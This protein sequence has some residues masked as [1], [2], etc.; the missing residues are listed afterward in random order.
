MV[1]ITEI[2]KVKMNKTRANEDMDDYFSDNPTLPVYS[3]TQVSNTYKV[4]LDEP[5][6]EPS[7]YRTVYSTLDAATENDIVE[8]HLNTPGGQVSS[9]LQIVNAISLCKATTIAICHA[10]VASAGTMIALN[11][12]KVQITPHNRWMIH[13][14][15]YGVNGHM[16]TISEQ[17]KFD[18]EYLIALCEDMY[19]GFLSQEEINDM[20]KNKKEIWLGE[21]EI[22]RRLHKRQEILIAQL[23]EQVKQLEESKQEAPKMSVTKKKK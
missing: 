4:F 8:I 13:A 17:V 11:C 16:Q 14:P 15:S 21:D 3:R 22:M 1:N 2:R 18:T 20:I 5:I 19:F 10:D 7:K 9:A 6:A 12:D 23:E